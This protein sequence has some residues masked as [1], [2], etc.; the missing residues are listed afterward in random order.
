MVVRYPR[1][2]LERFY[3]TEHRRGTD[4]VLVFFG[5]RFTVADLGLTPDEDKNTAGAVDR[6]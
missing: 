3:C 6:C 4:E 2:R 5:P 1:T